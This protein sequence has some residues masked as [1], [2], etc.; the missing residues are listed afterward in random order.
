MKAIF[1]IFMNRVLL[2]FFILV[3]VLLLASC[4][5][6][7]FANAC[8]KTDSEVQDAYQA[9]RDLIGHISKNI[10]CSNEKYT[11][12]WQMTEEEQL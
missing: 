5:H 11:Y 12:N 2:S 3:L 7:A 4:N 6:P 9:C 10:N 8:K 1:L